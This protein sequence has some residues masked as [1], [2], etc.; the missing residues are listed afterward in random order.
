MQSWL[1][2]GAF[3]LNGFDILLWCVNEM[4]ASDSLVSDSLVFFLTFH[5]FDR[6][7]DIL[8][9]RSRRV[10]QHNP[11]GS[12]W[13]WAS[14][15]YCLLLCLHPGSLRCTCD[16]AKSQWPNSTT[17]VKLHF[18]AT[19]NPPYGHSHSSSLTSGVLLQN[20]KKHT[21]CTHTVSSWNEHQQLKK[22]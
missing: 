16:I 18:P 11:A 15:V 12:S 1:C 2:F 22:N 3:E 13:W 7:R 4:V 21:H 19:T 8:L 6:I 14:N 10:S 20:V 9:L 5:V 17:Q